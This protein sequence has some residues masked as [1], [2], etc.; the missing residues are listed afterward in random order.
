MLFTVAWGKMIQEKTCSKK[1]RDTVP[2]LLK[3]PARYRVV[4]KG[5]DR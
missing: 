4:G 3:I 5:T 2:L 1:S